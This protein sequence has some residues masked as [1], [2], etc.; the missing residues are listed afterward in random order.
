[1][2]SPRKKPAAIGIKAAYPGFIPPALATS[3]TRYLL[4]SG[5]FTRSSS[6][7]TGSKPHLKDAAEYI[8]ELPKAE[9]DADERQAAM[10][11]LLL[12]AEHDGPPMFARASVS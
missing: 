2:P 8:T 6:T 4:A 1:M 9:H 11:A 12:L 7:A 3:T 10:Q 5:G